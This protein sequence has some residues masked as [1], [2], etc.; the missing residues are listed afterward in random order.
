MMHKRISLII[1]LLLLLGLQLAAQ[2]TKYGGSF[3]EL[4]VGSR[5]MAM[6]DA[7]ASIADDG[8]AFYWNPAGAATILRTDVSGMYASLFKSLVNHYHLGVTKPVYG[9]G[10]VSL[11]W[12]N[13]SV[14][15]IP[16]YWSDLL[17]DPSSSYDRRVAESTGSGN[18][19]QNVLSDSAS[20]FTNSSEDAFIITL[21]K[22]N[23]IDVDFGWQYF[24]MPITIPIGVNVKLLR[25]SLFSQ[26][27]SGIGFDFGT[28]LRFGLD[29]LFDDNRLGKVA[30]GVTV[31]DIWNTK[32]T[33]DTD[34]RHFD[35][36]KRSWL[37]GG[38]YLQPFSRLNGELLLA[39]TLK[40]TDRTTNHIGLEYLYYN[41]LA[42]RFGLTNRKFTAGVGFRVSL[43]QF[44]YAFR[45]HDLGGSHRINTS[46][47][48]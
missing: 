41:R 33:W 35:R 3:L 11:N 44:D 32:L 9:Q 7:Y 40:K 30:I 17:N 20:G 6:G 5:S 23:K 16:R 24:V 13:V 26:K 36:I 48:L 4:S 45:T 25:Q 15:D 14:D 47:T 28:M 38:S 12:V 1:G 39:Y 8:S 27:S 18:W 37:I 42:T 22:Q 31:K 21:A 34:S 19:E 46:I 2:G 43:F 10:S 29:D